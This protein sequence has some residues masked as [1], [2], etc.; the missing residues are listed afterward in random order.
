MGDVLPTAVEMTI[1][2][3][4]PQKPGQPPSAYRVIRVIPLACAK[5]ATDTGTT[6]GIQ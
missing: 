4:Y 3:D 1:D 6:G 2:I 5:P